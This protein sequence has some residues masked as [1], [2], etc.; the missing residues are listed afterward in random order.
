M[1]LEVSNHL[2]TIENTMR[3]LLYVLVAA[4]ILMLI[5]T[6]VAGNIL[7]RFILQPIK[8]LILTMRENKQQAGWQTIPI[9]NRS[10]DELYEMEST[11]NYMIETL[12]ENYEKQELFVSDASHELKTPISIIKSYA[13]LLQ[14][15]G[16][17]PEVFN[18]SIQAIDSEADRMQQLVNQMLLLAKNQND[19]PFQALDLGQ[20]IEK[21]IKTFQDAY[22]RNVVVEGSTA[23]LIVNGNKE[24]LQQVLYILM[25]NAVKY[26]EHE[27]IIKLNQQ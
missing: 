2:S 27:I 16:V 11:F 25:D 8:D 26:S 4:S 17:E 1:T 7:S 22:D 5:P 15:R 14:R 13:Q 21:T 24:Q 6:M 23:S 12:K 20:L 10:K 9:K 3:T 19:Q 18:E